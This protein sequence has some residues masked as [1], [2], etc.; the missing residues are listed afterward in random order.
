EQLL[1]QFLWCHGSSGKGKSK[2]AWE[3]VW[4]PKDEGGLVWD[5]IR[6]RD[7]KVNWY[8]MVW[9]PSCIPRHAIN[10]W[11]I[12][13][14]KLKTQ[15]LIPV[16]DVSS[17]LGVD[18]LDMVRDVSDQ[19]VKTAIFSMGNDKAPGPDGFTVAFFKEAW[20]VIAI[21]VTNAVREFFRNGTLLKEL[22]H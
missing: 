10:L 18:A 13:R 5:D 14:R 17:S 9:F 4:L 11:L 8:S 1:R 22:N 2:V 19:E 21:D 6:F 15:D 7:S 12:V 20:N 16:W 3:N